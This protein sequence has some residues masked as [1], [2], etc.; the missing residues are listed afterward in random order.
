[1]RRLALIL[2][3]VVPQHNAF[4]LVPG[5]CGDPVMIRETLRVDRNQAPASFGLPIEAKTFVELYLSPYGGWTLVERR[6]DG[7][8][9]VV[10][11]GTDWQAGAVPIGGAK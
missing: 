2:F 6:L 11:A 3:A 4:A 9:C 10:Q 8:A 7:T 1:M 5:T